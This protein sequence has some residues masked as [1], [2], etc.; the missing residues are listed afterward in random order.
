MLLKHVQLYIGL[1]KYMRTCLNVGRSLRNAKHTSMLRASTCVDHF[2][3][4]DMH[5][6]IVIPYGQTHPS[7]C[8]NE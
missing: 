1:S 5:V 2:Y 7:S 4:L 6:L 3:N 8:I